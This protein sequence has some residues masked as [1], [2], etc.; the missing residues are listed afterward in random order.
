MPPG[1]PDP[2]TTPDHTDPAPRRV[3][4]RQLVAGTVGHLVEFY[5]FLVYSYVAIYFANQFFPSDSE[6]SLVP[7]LSAFG[8]FA[9]G[10]FARPVAGLFLGVFADRYGRRFGL[11]LSIMMMAGGS[12][13]I[14][15]A[16]TYQQIGVAAP[17][18]LVVARL[19][20]GLSAG[21]EYSAAA[22]FLT[23]S[24]PAGRRGFYASFL[25]V[26]SSLGKL[27]ALGIV[28]VLVALLGEPAMR[29]Y[30]WRIP[31]LIGALGAVA[32]WWIRRGT[33]ETLE[34]ADETKAVKVGVF[35]AVRAHPKASLQVFGIAAG[36]G[37]G[38]YFWA[39]YFPTYATINGGYSTATATA[40]SL[41]GLTAYVFLSPIIGMISDR[42]GRKP[43][44]YV[45]GFGLTVL[46]VPL[47]D[48]MQ[49]GV[50]P[51][52][53]AQL[54][55]LVALACGTSILGSVMAE[56]FPARTRVTGL[57]FP[58][59]VSIALFGGTVSVIGT[60]LEEAGAGGLFG[61]YMAATALVTLIT[62]VTLRETG[63]S[64]LSRDARAELS[65]RNRTDPVDRS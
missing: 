41:V 18:I 54:V 65:I 52:L 28:T 7:L 60:A 57:G 44:L 26:A 45:F 27:V 42:V 50:V 17:I 24:A 62:A 20:Q 2:S 32:A 63:H 1:S 16:P 10:F 4:S 3:S 15:V 64:E 39:T 19:L 11:T 46:T 29:D 40:V 53:I 8:V 22:T 59:A 33:D 12:L 61:W 25:F 51:L 23:E 31:F 30:G 5:D 21:S 49:M 34:K 36:I 14:A 9:V 13:L 43:V 35:D 48:L 56:M 38:Q 37:V 6:N 58:Y 47:L 55:G